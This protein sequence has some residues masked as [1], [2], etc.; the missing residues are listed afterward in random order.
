MKTKTNILGKNLTVLSKNN[1]RRAVINSGIAY[2]LKKACYL[3]K[4]TQILCLLQ[5]GKHK[6]FEQEVVESDCER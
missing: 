4:Y 6:I 3:S 5:L 1:L 2:L